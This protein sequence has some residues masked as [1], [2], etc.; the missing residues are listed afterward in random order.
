MED[1][2]SGDG[3]VEGECGMGSGAAGDRETSRET[4]GAMRGECGG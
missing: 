1:G 3:S 2:E 4:D